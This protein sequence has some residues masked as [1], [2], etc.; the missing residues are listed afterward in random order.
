MAVDMAVPAIAFDTRGA[1]GLWILALVLLGLSFGQ[2]VRSLRLPGAERIGSSVTD[3]PEAP[4][5]KD[6][7]PPEDSLLKD[8]AECPTAVRIG[9]EGYSFFLS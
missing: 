8:L 3:T 7:H 2:A 9:V 6:E 4:E 5:R 1:Y